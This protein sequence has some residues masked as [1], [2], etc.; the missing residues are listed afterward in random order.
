MREDALNEQ[1]EQNRRLEDDIRLKQGQLR[2][3]E[4]LSGSL[5]SNINRD[6]AIQVKNAALAIHSRWEKVMQTINRRHVSLDE[7]RRRASKF[8]EKVI[9]LSD[10]I[11]TTCSQLEEDRRNCDPRQ[12]KK[13]LSK[14]AE[15]QRAVEKH[16]T[17]Y[18]EVVKEANGMLKVA[19]LPSDKPAI[20]NELKRIQADWATLNQASWN[21]SRDIQDSMVSSGRL[22][23]A[24]ETLEEWLIKVE[25]ELSER[26]PVEGDLDTVEKLI[27]QH[28]EFKRD[29]EERENSFAQLR[30]LA[31]ELS[32]ADSAWMRPQISGLG[33][34]WEGLRTLSRK[35]DDKLARAKA[36]AQEFQDEVNNTLD[37][38]GKAE[39]RLDSIA[40]LLDGENTPSLVEKAKRH[41]TELESD[42]GKNKLQLDRAILLG[43]T[44]LSNAD[45]AAVGTLKHW[46]GALSAGWQEVNAWIDQ[47]GE[48]IKRMESD[49]AENATR[50]DKLLDWL[51]TSQV[52]LNTRDN[53]PLPD[54][55]SRL[56]HLANEHQQFQE[57]ILARQTEFDE[58]IRIYRKASHANVMRENYGSLKRNVRNSTTGLVEFKNQKAAMLHGTWQSGTTLIDNGIC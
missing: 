26:R 7:N 27:E 4:D 19:K 21:Y 12:G 6:D 22:I 11:E 39:E 1:I 55:L 28:R 30:R 3:L 15:T 53:E 17:L 40:L 25:P 46:I 52:K 50:L 57:E 31:S 9:D 8:A 47:L 33:S 35:R 5:R 42:F 2:T 38:L 16:E 13:L 32:V 23:D 56:K 44:I 48:R 10:F 24:L 34:R 20:E 41:Q 49:E 58:L 36:R 29:L 37:W 18:D 54:E 45:S 14:H 51:R 43:N